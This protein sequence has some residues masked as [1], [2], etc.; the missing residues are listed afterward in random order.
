MC[1]CCTHAN[2]VNKLSALSNGP[3]VLNWYKATRLKMLGE[4]PPTEYHSRVR[5]DGGRSGD[6][7]IIPPD[8]QQCITDQWKEIITAKLGFEN[9]K[10]MRDAWH[11][12]QKLKT[13]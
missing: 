9:L 11:K 4:D 2:A 6:G 13:V 5:R 7:K 12:E 8:V 10:D 3:F 1:A